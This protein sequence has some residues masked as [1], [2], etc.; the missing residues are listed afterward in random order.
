M[1]KLK[2]EYENSDAQWVSWEVGAYCA[3]LYPD[4]SQWYRGKVTKVIHKHLIEVSI[5]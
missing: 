4:D 1:E 3:V 2:A 5:D